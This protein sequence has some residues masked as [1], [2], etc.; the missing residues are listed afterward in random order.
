MG[1]KQ[2]KGFSG[3]ERK[4]GE[5]SLNFICKVGIKGDNNIKGILVWCLV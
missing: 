3:I 1:E 2:A 5:P 4:E